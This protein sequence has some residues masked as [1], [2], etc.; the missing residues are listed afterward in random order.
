MDVNEFMQAN[1]AAAKSTD[2]L[3]A[4]IRPFDKEITTLFHNGY[5]GEQV[6][7]FLEAN[8]VFVKKHELLLARYRIAKNNSSESKPA[9]TI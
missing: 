6:V 5:T 7:K 8:N 4:L 3:D 1:A 2:E 9:A